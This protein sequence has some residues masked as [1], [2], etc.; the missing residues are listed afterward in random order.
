MTSRTSQTA[1]VDEEKTP[2]YVSFKLVGDNDGDGDSDDDSDKAKFEF[3][4]PLPKYSSDACVWT[5]A[6]AILICDT[7]YVW[8]RTTHQTCRCRRVARRQGGDNLGDS[9]RV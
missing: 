9:D 2:I 3:E 8:S 5:R 7:L 4:H 1:K 6:N